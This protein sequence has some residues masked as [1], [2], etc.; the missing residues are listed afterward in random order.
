MRPITIS[1]LAL[2]GSLL[3][4]AAVEAQKPRKTQITG[5]RV[6]FQAGLL[7]GE[8]GREYLFKPGHWTPISVDVIAGD[9]GLSKGTLTVETIDGDDVQN[10]YTI[11]ISLE[12]NKPATFLTYARPSGMG[13]EI[14]VIVRDENQTEIL[15][16]IYNAMALDDLLF[17]NVGSHLTGLRQSLVKQADELRNNNKNAGMA[18]VNEGRVAYVESVQQLPERWFA[19]D[20]VDLMILTTGNKDFIT[21]LLNQ[22]NRL[23]PLAE[24]V[25]RGG[26]LVISTGRNHDL[27]RQLLKD[28]T[29]DT[30]AVEI[31]PGVLQLPRLR[32]IES[33]LLDGR[34]M[35]FENSEDADGKTPPIEVARL[36]IK[37]KREAE[38]LVA[39][40]DE[41]RQPLIVR[42]PHGLG[43]VTLIA[44]DLDEPPFTRW[45]GQP[46]FW[47]KLQSEIGVSLTA[48]TSDHWN[49]DYQPDLSGLLRA[50]SEEFPNVSNVS[51]GWVAL[52]IFVYILVVGPLDYFFLKK[53]VKRLEWTWIT[54]PTV[55]L[56]VSIAAYFTAYALKGN[57]LRINKTDL[58]NIDLEGRTVYG[59]T[60][61]TL[62]SP[63]L[64]HYTIGI[65]PAAPQWAAEES[66]DPQK[67]KASSVV[68]SWMGRADDR[69]GGFGRSRSQSLFR[70]SY[71]YA[72]DA[73]GLEGVPIP[74][75]SMKSFTAGWER[76]LGPGQAPFTADLRYEA[77]PRLE[78]TIT[79][80]LPVALNNVYLIYGGGREGG[81]V[82][83]L[84]G[85]LNPGN[86]QRIDLHNFRP[87]TDWPATAASQVSYGRYS[88]NTA[89]R[90]TK[91]DIF[92]RMMFHDTFST[93]G[94]L[95]NLT[96][97]G[98]DESWRL[99]LKN[100][101]IL[102]GKAV[103]QSASAETVTAS[104]AS[105]TRLWL[106]NL[107]TT[108][109]ARPEILGLM[110]QDTYVRVFIPIKSKDGEEE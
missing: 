76:P 107:P 32:G 40:L 42:I 69:F 7:P 91:D 1:S 60:W 67:A 74:V 31:E 38:V 90:M 5:I 34:R 77:G 23:H 6:G 99:R 75:W 29:N 92:K 88:Q 72:A 94:R 95:R 64:Q 70:R 30:A 98:L 73:R 15:K 96:L 56:V 87:I 46:E 63:R 16:D 14:A 97:R 105:P 47:K 25:R 78:G 13:S 68:L 104:P 4:P 84:D 86:P 2:I 100:E 11:P 20:A 85:T 58:V 71:N 45:G 106:G 8:T 37:P 103:P 55:V 26:R 10:T 52:F 79:N 41:A 3:L 28:L 62:F 57:D 36:K 59:N 101:V 61:F 110:K 48:E 44:F 21:D 19:Y 102:V 50:K 54:F 65:E 12:P 81:K 43:Q 51:F 18:G 89:D 17:L 66:D 35:P 9:A 82:F 109:E 83:A 53:V 93:A 39:T 22:K 108:G 27:G 33:W 49:Y 80:H 24:W